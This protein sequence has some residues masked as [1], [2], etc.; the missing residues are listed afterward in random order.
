MV[1]W[2]RAPEAKALSW[3][4]S[5]VVANALIKAKA[6]VVAWC[7]HW[8]ED[9]GGDER[10]YARAM[11]DHFGLEMARNSPDQAMAFKAA[12]SASTASGVVAQEHMKRTL[13]SK[14]R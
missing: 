2:S 14:N 3:I 8:T 10:I 12:P 13:P 1:P 5:A 11:A 4:I 6:P 9:P 7:N